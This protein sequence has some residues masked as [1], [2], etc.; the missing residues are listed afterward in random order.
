MRGKVR[1]MAGTRKYSQ[2]LR[3]RA[4]GLV[5]D[6]S[7]RGAARR[8]AAR[9]IASQLNINYEMLRRWVRQAEI[10]SG[11]RPGLSSE[12]RERLKQLEKENRELRRVNEILKSASAFFAR[13]LDQPRTR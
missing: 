13:E 6:S 2:G 3:E 1:V 5:L 12:E 11:A 10:D 8:G 9:R 4:V 7:E